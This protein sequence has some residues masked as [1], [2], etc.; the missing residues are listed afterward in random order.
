MKQLV[1]TEGLHLHGSCVPQ[2]SAHNVCSMDSSGRDDRGSG[3]RMIVPTF[4]RVDFY[5][6]SFFFFYKCILYSG[7]GFLCSSEV[8]EN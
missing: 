2:G 4:T 6:I 5:F 1:K 7:N 8:T 3:H